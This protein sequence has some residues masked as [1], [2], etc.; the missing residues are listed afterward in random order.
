[1]WLAKHVIYSFVSFNYLFGLSVP[2]M[3]PYYPYGFLRAF[4]FG[5][6]TFFI[7]LFLFPF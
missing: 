1:M 5:F 3:A 6:N 4:P 7:P 2:C